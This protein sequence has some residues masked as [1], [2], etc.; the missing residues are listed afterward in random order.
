MAVNKTS[1][2]ITSGRSVGPI[3]TWFLRHVSTSI[4]ALGRL[5]RQ[6][7]ASLMTVL[8]IAVTLALPAAMQLL[9]LI[10]I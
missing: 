2:L 5:A 10:H 8:V 6:P 4:G 7:F 9:S 3:S 1:E